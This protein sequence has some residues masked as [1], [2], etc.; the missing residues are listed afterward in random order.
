MFA[1]PKIDPLAEVSRA[2]GASAT[3]TVHGSLR[4]PSG[5]VGINESLRCA[6]ALLSA[7]VL[8]IVVL[9][10]GSNAAVAQLPTVGILDFNSTGHLELIADPAHSAYWNGIFYF[11]AHADDGRELFASDGTA[12]GTL[13]L[14]DVVPGVDSSGP[15]FLTRVGGENAASARVFFS[16]TTPDYGTELWVTDGTSLGT[17]LAADL[18][19]NDMGSTPHSLTAFNGDLY[20]SAEAVGE[21]GLFKIDPATLAT[22]ALAPL[23]VSLEVFAK[24]EA[25]GGRLYF[26]G[27]SGGVKQI[28]STDGLTTVAETALACNDIL[29]IHAVAGEVFF[30]CEFAST[31]ELLRLDG[32]VASGASLVYRTAIP[33]TI[34][35]PVA[36]AGLLYFVLNEEEIYAYNNGTGMTDQVTS[37]GSAVEPEDLFKYNGGVLFTADDTAGREVYFTDGT[38]TTL[39]QD[40]NEGIGDSRPEEFTEHEGLV[41]FAADS[42]IVG[43]ELFVTDGTV[44]GTGLAADNETGSVADLRSAKHTDGNLLWWAWQRS[45][46]ERRDTAGNRA[47]RQSPELLIQTHEPVCGASGTWRW[48]RAPCVLQRQRWPGPRTGGLRR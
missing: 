37:F 19:P 28:W 26:I 38:T 21:R 29:D 35:Y 39:L 18:A 6:A 7:R 36:S 12:A 3:L 2:R 47:G 22:T 4:A 17:E 16:A 14:K 27:L 45:V 43:R 44:G 8:L 30:V 23:V 13:Q 15:L 20:F 40:I 32:G 11:S 5:R 33:G 24:M 31:M 34:E 48:R 41:Y 1:K 10:A 9:L 25:T 46:V 42:N